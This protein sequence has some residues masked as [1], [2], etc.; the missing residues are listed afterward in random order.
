MLS[1]GSSSTSCPL[2]QGSTW[3]AS[4]LSL[5]QCRSL[6]IWQFNDLKSCSGEKIHETPRCSKLAYITKWSQ[7]PVACQQCGIIWLDPWLHA[8]LVLILYSIRWG[9]LSR[10]THIWLGTYAGAGEWALVATSCL[11]QVRTPLFVVLTSPLVA[12]EVIRS[13]EVVGQ[14]YNGIWVWYTC[15]N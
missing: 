6:Q 12:R 4:D 11:C 2:T 5:L 14:G 15:I 10:A 9:Q 1:P 3:H 13:Q 8:S 7:L